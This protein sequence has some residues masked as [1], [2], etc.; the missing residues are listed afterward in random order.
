M[1]ANNFSSRI[2]IVCISVWQTLKLQTDANLLLSST[3]GDGWPPTP[4]ERC[5]GATAVRVLM[6]WRAWMD[7]S[8]GHIVTAMLK[9]Y[10]RRLKHVTTCKSCISLLM[11]GS[12]LP[13]HSFFM[14]PFAVDVIMLISC[15]SEFNFSSRLL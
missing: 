2:S 9:C 13:S 6:R 7:V 15:P 11:L 10:C 4:G 8:H 3:L 5:S 12:L 1:E 14:L